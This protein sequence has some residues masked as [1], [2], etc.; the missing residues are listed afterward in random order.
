MGAT[1]GESDAGVT[2]AA[3]FK[4]A[5]AAAAAAAATKTGE[6]GKGSPSAVVFKRRDSGDDNDALMQLLPSA[7]RQGVLCKVSCPSSGRGD[8][9]GD[10]VVLLG[11]TL[12]G[13]SVLSGMDGAWFERVCAFLALA[14]AAAGTGER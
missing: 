10:S 13:E 3:A 9:G 2:V 6:Q 5:T 12:A 8:G 4:Q 11:S 7:C 14:P 1:G